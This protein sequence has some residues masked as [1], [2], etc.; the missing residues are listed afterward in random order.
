MPY[1]FF[2][3][4]VAPAY[5]GT[6]WGPSVNQA[7]PVVDRPMSICLPVHFFPDYTNDRM[8]IGFD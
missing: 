1:S 6:Y 7:V 5:I 2:L 4:R 3:F 8:L